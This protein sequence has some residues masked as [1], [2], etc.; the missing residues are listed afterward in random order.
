MSHTPPPLPAAALQPPPPPK[1]GIPLPLILCGIVGVLVVGIAIL[2]GLAAPALRRTKKKADQVMALNNGRS[3][4]LAM[5]DFSAE[6]DSLPDRETARKVAADSH[7]S[8][9]LSGDTANDYFRQLIAAGVVRAEDGFWAK[10]PYSP[11]RPDN[12]ITGSE[13]LKAG[14][15]GFGYLMNGGRAIGAT[16]PNRIIAVTPLFQAQTNGE[17]DPGPLGGKAVLVRLDG[18]VKLTP[19][20]PDRKVEVAGRKTLLDTGADTVWGTETTPVI[21]APQPR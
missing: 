12:N 5:N 15:V 14:E 18:S 3:M 16:D 13:A 4:M 19:I 11:K 6:Y 8:L 7:S 20:R 17:F 1:T 21:K 10:T 2:A 9:D